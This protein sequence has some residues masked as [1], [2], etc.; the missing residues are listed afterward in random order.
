MFGTLNQSDRA[1]RVRYETSA[2]RMLVEW[3][4]DGGLMWHPIRLVS[5]LYDA[6]AIGVNR[7]MTVPMSSLR[8]VTT[9]GVVRLSAF[10]G[11]R[12]SSLMPCQSA[13]S[14]PFARPE[15]PPR[16]FVLSP[17]DNSTVLLDVD[18][19]LVLQGNESGFFIF[20]IFFVK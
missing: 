18:G 2:P 11:L 14:S 15:L 20:F 17:V 4:P 12:A 3:S 13:I 5:G 7:R 10:G 9:N 16:L 1:D 6:D 19:A 8:G